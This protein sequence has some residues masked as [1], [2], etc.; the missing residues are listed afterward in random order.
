MT[1][2][3][4]NMFENFIAKL[5]QLDD[6][7]FHALEALKGKVK[8]VVRKSFPDEAESHVAEIDAISFSPRRLPGIMVLGGGPSERAATRAKDEQR[9]K[10]AWDSG[11]ISFQN[12]LETLVF[13]LALNDDASSDLHRKQGNKKKKVFIVHGHDDGA[14]NTVARFLERSFDLDAVILHEQIN[15]SKTIIEKFEHHAAQADFAIVLLTPDDLGEAKAKILKVTD[16]QPRARQNVIF[17]L[18]YFFA[19]LGRN[20]VIALVKGEIK[21]PA[22]IDGVVYIPLDESD[23]WQLPVARELKS[24]GFDIDLNALA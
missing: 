3:F 5:S 6:R 24:A 19:K 23:A 17:E 10:D 11:V 21:N 22:D 2:S 8:V 20:S 13:A 7:D 14:K 15:Q 18:G 1:S 12:F 4:R 16:L 9:A